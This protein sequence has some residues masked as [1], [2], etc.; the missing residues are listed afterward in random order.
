MEG[1]TPKQETPDKELEDRKN[2]NKHQ[3]IDDIT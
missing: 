3:F 1:S 2:A